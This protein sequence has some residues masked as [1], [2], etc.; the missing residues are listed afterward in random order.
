MYISDAILH[1]FTYDVQN[2]NEA[3]RLFLVFIYSLCKAFVHILYKRFET[4]LFTI[5]CVYA[6]SLFNY[7][8]RFKLDNPKQCR[9]TETLM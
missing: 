8:K 6:L 9:R 2:I 7:T 3:F 1:C 5:Y 4:L